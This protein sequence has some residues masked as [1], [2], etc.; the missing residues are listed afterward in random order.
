[1]GDSPARRKAVSRTAF[2]LTPPDHLGGGVMK[3]KFV[4]QI[5]KEIVDHILD[6]VE[7]ARW[8]GLALTR[9]N[10]L[11]Q[12][13]LAETQAEL[14]RL[15]QYTPVRK[16]DF[17]EQHTRVS[18]LYLLLENL[19]K[20]RMEAKLEVANIPDGVDLSCLPHISKVISEKTEDASCEEFIKS[21]KI[22]YEDDLQ[23][24]IQEPRK[25]PVFVNQKQLKFRKKV[26]EDFTGI[27]QN[28]KYTYY[29]GESESKEYSKN[30]KRL[31]EMNTKLINFFN[32]EFPVNFPDKFELYEK[33]HGE[34]PGIYRFKF[35]I[36]DNI[37]ESLNTEKAN[38]MNKIEEY[39]RTLKK[40]PSSEI[41]QHRQLLHKLLPLLKTAHENELL[42][43]DEA[44][45]LIRPQEEVIYDHFEN[46]EDLKSAQ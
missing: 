20:A 27:L 45:D 39:S 16:D 40:I 17:E 36:T 30:Q 21:L 34:R 38:L 37:N 46:A 25:K 32:K 12:T 24:K 8:N 6:C 28:P 33:C 35:Q 26:W 22:S 29:V 9:P 23:V 41:V 7:K 3:F 14:N 19:D 11:F 18:Q 42:T 4:D 31:G 10:W 5:E 1:M 15:E 2:P 43:E 44:R 13:R